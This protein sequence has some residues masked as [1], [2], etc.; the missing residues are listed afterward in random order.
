VLLAGWLAGCG[1][2]VTPEPAS[3]E[4]SSVDGASAAP[5]PEPVPSARVGKSGK[6]ERITFVPEV[7]S[8]P[9]DARAPVQPAATV[10]GQLE[11]P[12]NVAEV[13]WWDG[14]A[15]AGDPFG[16]TVIAGHVDSADG[17]SGFFRRLER[18]EKGDRVTLRA[19]ERRLSYRVSSVA[20][21][22]RQ[23]LADRSPAFDQSGDHRLVLITCTGN[24]VRERGGY[25]KNLVVTA[26]PIGLAQ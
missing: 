4:P 17:D 24:Y 7:V 22:A 20:E 23:A 3:P 26:T 25:E 1:P 16:H 13:G 14:S 15:R 9:G 5:A 11:V 2:A 19:G 12:E 10:D 6:K 8:L 18:I 21:V